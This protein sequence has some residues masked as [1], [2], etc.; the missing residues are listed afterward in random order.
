M[1]CPVHG[2]PAHRSASTTFE[3]VYMTD[4]ALSRVK[5]LSPTMRRLAEKPAKSE[6]TRLETALEVCRL[7]VPPHWCSLRSKTPLAAVGNPTCA[8]VCRCVTV[9]T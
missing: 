5:A 3:T 9:T 4:V 8:C 1:I 7:S 6:K 2:V